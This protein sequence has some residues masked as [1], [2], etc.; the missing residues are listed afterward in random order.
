VVGAVGGVRVSAPALVGFAGGGLAVALMPVVHY[1]LDTDGEPVPEPDHRAWNQ[2]CHDERPPRG[3]MVVA[4]DWPA[5]DVLV[6]TVFTG[7]DYSYGGLAA[8]RPLLYETM[9]RRRRSWSGGQ[10]RWHDRA[11]A[12]AA[13]RRIVE[14][15]RPRSRHA[16]ER[17]RSVRWRVGT[18]RW[19]RYAR[20][21]R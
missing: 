14:L 9:V 6:S 15:L 5:P 4:R 3:A 10:W 18:R 1:V 19:R 13:H 7:F 17:T 2:W 20:R 16:R 21:S 11:E 12:L 8:S